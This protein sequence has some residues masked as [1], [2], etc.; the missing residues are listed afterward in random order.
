MRIVSALVTLTLAGALPAA[1]QQGPAPAPGDSLLRVNAI[2]Q[3]RVPSLGR[4]W[5]TGQVV[6]S[7]SALDCLAVMIPPAQDGGR[8][9]FV[10]LKGVDSLIVDRRTNF[11]VFAT[12]VLPGSEDWTAL[13]PA[14]LKTLQAQCTGKRAA[15]RN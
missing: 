13:T 7:T 6:R 11:G 1:A 15:G 4:A 10:F 12:K 2:V 14:Q 9:R 3:I 5:F 8:D